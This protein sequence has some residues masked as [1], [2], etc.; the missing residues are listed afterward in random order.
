[1]VFVGATAGGAARLGI[2]QALDLG[3]WSWD[4]VAINLIGS[5]LLGALMGWF[6]VH[7]AP[8]W[9]PGLGAGVLGGFTTFSSMAAPHP[10]APVPGFVLLI[11]TLL[12]A[13][14][15]AALGW[16]MTEAIALRRGPT[17]LPLDME[18]VEAEVEGFDGFEGSDLESDG[19]PRD[20]VTS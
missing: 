18:S 7:D 13:S 3:A 1:M 9:I 10:D 6:A 14:L 11:G 17:R 20:E 4:I 15:A 19:I 2:D 5:A 12:C 16:S 8:W